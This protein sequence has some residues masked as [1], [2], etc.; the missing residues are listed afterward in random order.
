MILPLAKRLFPLLILSLLLFPEC[1]APKRW[2]SSTLLFFDTVCELRIFCSQSAF[3]TSEDAIRLVF[4]EVEK[5]FA[6]G[7]KV[8]SSPVVLNLFHRAMD[9]YRNTEGCFDIT[10][11]PLSRVWGF[12]DGNPHVPPIEDIQAALLFVGMDEIDEKN[13]R[14]FLP[15]GAELDWGGIAKGL[16][17]DLAS[18]ALIQSGIQRGFINAGGD[19][20][21]WG[22]NPDNQAW[23]V[24]IKHPREGGFLG[25]I[26]L[27]NKGAATTGDY[28][29]F[30]L[31]EG[32]RYHHV[33]DPRTGYPPQDKQSVTVVG[34][35][36]LVC[37]ALSTAVFVSFSPEAMMKK[38]PEYGAVVV[39][40]SGKVLV[41]GNDCG[42]RRAD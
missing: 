37:D 12:R 39:L 10:V 16:G 42:F 3:R 33:F 11:G 21:C 31:E 8:V 24:G 23:R 40:S 13:E 22:K 36:T 7:A 29:R 15:S 35:E 38:Y 41:I 32:T 6:P 30:F 17:V 28:Q 34:P 19:L 4:S 27:S 26:S 25:V 5:R 14:L 2:R 9:V 18:Q 1:G 20:Y